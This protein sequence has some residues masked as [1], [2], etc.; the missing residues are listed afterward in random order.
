MYTLASED[1]RLPSPPWS[2]VQAACQILSRAEC[3]SIRLSASWNTQKKERVDHTKNSNP[4]NI[5][6]LDTENIENEKKERARKH[7]Y[8]ETEKKERERTHEKSKK[9]SVRTQETPDQVI[10][11]LKHTKERTH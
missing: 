3:M 7:K 10:W 11:E 6:R 4:R 9:Q 8:F 5:T 2:S 1:A